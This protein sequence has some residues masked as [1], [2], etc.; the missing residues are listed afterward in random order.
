MISIANSLSDNN[1]LRDLNVSANQ[2]DLRVVA[3]NFC[4]AL[5]NTSSIN[6]IYLSNHTLESIKSATFNAHDLFLGSVAALLKLNK[7]TR[8]RN[9][10]HVAIKKILLYHPPIDMEPLFD[11]SL[12]DDDDS[13]QDLK[14]LPHVISWFETAKEAIEM[15]SLRMRRHAQRK[16]LSTN[17][18]ECKKLSAIYQFVTAMPM[19]FVSATHDKGVDRKRKR[20][21]D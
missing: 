11:L 13:G 8:T 19:L 12:E 17:D 1:H 6:D 16:K 15:N 18:L 2:I 4:K 7:S 10:R 21:F 20:S 9:K 3:D 14:A 5:C